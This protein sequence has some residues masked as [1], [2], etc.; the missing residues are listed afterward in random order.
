MEDLQKIRI[1]YVQLKKLIFNIQ[2]NISQRFLKYH[3]ANSPGQTF[4]EM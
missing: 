2:L 3:N 1:L 4:L